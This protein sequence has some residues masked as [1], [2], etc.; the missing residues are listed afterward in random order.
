MVGN[1]S[2]AIRDMPYAKGN[3]PLRKTYQIFDSTFPRPFTR[4]STTARLK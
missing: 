1:M 4:M 3:N 2:L